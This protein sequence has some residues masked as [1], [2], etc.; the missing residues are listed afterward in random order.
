MKMSKFTQKLQFLFVTYPLSLGHFGYEVIWF[1]NQTILVNLVSISWA[2][3]DEALKVPRASKTQTWKVTQVYDL[4]ASLPF[5]VCK[6]FSLMC[7]KM[8]IYHKNKVFHSNDT[9]MHSTWLREVHKLS[10]PFP[11]QDPELWGAVCPAFVEATAH[12][13]QCDSTAP[14]HILPVVRG[15]LNPV[16]RVAT[17]GLC[18]SAEEM[19]LLGHGTTLSVIGRWCMLNPL[20]MA[21]W[22]EWEA[23]ANA[24]SISLWQSPSSPSTPSFSQANSVHS[25]QRHNL[26]AF[27]DSYLNL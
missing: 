27:K 15:L 3:P 4:S 19:V 9:K 22:A 6:P 16:R 13:G 7:F 26:N 1:T 18:S 10:C 25:N 20:P 5:L 21:E 17:D 12:C 11:Q 14:T 23:A 8:F 2:H 24:N